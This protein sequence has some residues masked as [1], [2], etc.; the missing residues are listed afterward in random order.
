ML[1][2]KHLELNVTGM[3]EEPLGI[4]IRSAEGLLGLVAGCLIGSKKVLLF[5]H[6]AH[7]SPAPAGGGL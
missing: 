7:A 5:A 1:V 6:D 3:L 2:A 4:D